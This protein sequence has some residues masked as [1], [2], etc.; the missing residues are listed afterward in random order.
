MGLAVLAAL[1]WGFFPLTCKLI[2]QAQFPP[3][4]MVGL[5]FLGASIP[6]LFLWK[7]PVVSF[8]RVF[9]ISMTLSANQLFFMPAIRENVG[10][11]LVSV[12]TESQ[13]FFTAILSYFFLGWKLPV[14]DVV[15]LVVCFV[16]ILLIGTSMGLE[17]GNFWVFLLLLGAAFT[18]GMNNVQLSALRDDPTPFVTLS[19]ANILPVIPF[20][21]SSYV[22]ERIEFLHSLE[23]LTWTQGIQILLMSFMGGGVALGIWFY[24]LRRNNPAHVS[25]FALLSPFIGVVA[26]VVLMDEKFHVLSLFGGGLV[27]VGLVLLQIFQYNSKKTS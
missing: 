22:V 8:R 5:R 11:G 25:S 26:A 20:L 3:L 21:G 15:S 7:F 4:M 14:Q 13:V 6:L 24:L 2:A 27:L 17:G 1:I 19:W 16:G 9:W 18:W 12:L 10:A 23:G